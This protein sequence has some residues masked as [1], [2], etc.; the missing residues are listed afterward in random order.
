M[1]RSYI[2]NDISISEE[3][4]FEVITGPNGSG[5]TLYIKQV[6]CIVVMAQ[7]GMFVPAVQC[8]INIR[9]RILT[10][11]GSAESIEHSVSSF[12]GEM[13][14]TGYI[15][16]NA[17]KSSLVEIDELGK[18]TSIVDGIAIAFAVAEKL[19]SIGAFTLFVTHFPQLTMLEEMYPSVCNIHLATDI[20]NKL[21]FLHTINNGACDIRFGY[22]VAMAEI[23][24]FSPEFISRAK[25]KM[26][27]VKNAFPL[28]LKADNVDHHLV[29]AAT[30]SRNLESLALSSMSENALHDF[31]DQLRRRISQSTQRSIVDLLNRLDGEQSANDNVAATKEHLQTHLKR[32][33][34]IDEPGQIVS[35]DL[36]DDDQIGDGAGLKDAR[37]TKI[38]NN[39][40]FLTSTGSLGL[41]ISKIVAATAHI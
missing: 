40:N 37:S 26:L 34:E 18:S 5:K 2:P 14:E 23:C 10:R 31:K 21:Q 30:L 36:E 27:D 24:G 8:R 9:D 4:S 3:I 32:P 12:D 11:M 28:L 19:I 7:I 15:L 41:S 25:G 13:R 38:K 16:N 29:A 20:E 6:A 17:T 33:R 39:N 1:S 35:D 22:G